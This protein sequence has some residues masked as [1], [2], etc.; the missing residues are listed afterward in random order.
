M[1]KFP[2]EWPKWVYFVFGCCAAAT[3]IGVAISCTTKPV[4][5]HRP[6]DPPPTVSCRTVLTEA[7]F[8]S[9]RVVRL[10]TVGMQAGNNSNEL[11]YLRVFGSPAV[12]IARFVEP[13]PVPKPQHC[14]GRCEWKDGSPVV[15]IDCRPD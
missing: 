15:V 2:R 8:Y 12:L 11:V 13:V 10:E 4:N 9:G 5:G 3:G 7:G 14:V 6:A 1:G